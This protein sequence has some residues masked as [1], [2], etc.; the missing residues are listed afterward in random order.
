MPAGARGLPARSLGV[1]FGVG[2]SAVALQ[3]LVA[4]V[5]QVLDMQVA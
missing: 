1:G 2:E 5:Q 3:P 4:P